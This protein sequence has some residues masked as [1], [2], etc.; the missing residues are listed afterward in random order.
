MLNRKNSFIIGSDPEMFLQEKATGCIVS[1]IPYIPGD[2]HDP[3]QIP[4]LSEGHNIQTDNVMVEYCVPATPYPE[5]LLKSIKD[6][7]EYTNSI[8]PNHL[9][10]VV[11]SSAILDME[12]LK[13]RK[14]RQFG[15]EPDYNA[16]ADATENNCPRPAPGLRSCGGHVHVGYNSPDDV[17][18]MAI[19]RAMDIFLGIPSIILDSDK[20][21]KEIY[22]KAGA[23]RFKS[24][25]FEYRVLSNFW[26]QDEHL[27][28]LIYEGVDEAISFAREGK[29]LTDEQQLDVQLCINTGDEGLAHK[30][31]RELGLE[32]MLNKVLIYVD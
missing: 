30:L 16:W 18:S 10:V 15:C 14:A 19:V 23:F 21:R 1:A 27:I 22:G 5:Q 11:K 32:K 25:G 7:I 9:Q 3:Y 8:I 6:C 29:S 4:S 31:I 24:Y 26:T 13:D 20:R 28:N 17:T 12:F 2:K